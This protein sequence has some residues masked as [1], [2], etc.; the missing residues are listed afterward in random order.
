MNDIRT[1]VGPYY[2][3]GHLFF[4]EL[5]KDGSYHIFGMLTTKPI[6]KNSPIIPELLHPTTNVKGGAEPQ[7]YIS[8]PKIVVLPKNTFSLVTTNA[9]IISVEPC[10]SL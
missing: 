2:S 3:P 9:K 1:V 4:G 5:Q 8:F 6:V 7:Y 10:L